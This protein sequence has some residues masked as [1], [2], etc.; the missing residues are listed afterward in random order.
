MKGIVT[1]ETKRRT[2]KAEGSPKRVLQAIE[3][4]KYVKTRNS[5][6]DFSMMFRVVP[7]VLKE[8][9][10]DTDKVSAT[11]L[12]VFRLIAIRG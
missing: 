9:S 5:E 2:K 6:R 7:D 8:M 3:M 12:A 4:M 1:S 11:C 10:D